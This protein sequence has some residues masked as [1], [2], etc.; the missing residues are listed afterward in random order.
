MGYFQKQLIYNFI[1]FKRCHTEVKLLFTSAIDRH[2]C[3]I[4]WNY[5]WEFLFLTLRLKLFIELR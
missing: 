5:N 1:I 2:L 4:I 3:L